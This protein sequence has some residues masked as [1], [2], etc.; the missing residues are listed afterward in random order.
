M[1]RL[2]D[3]DTRAA[4][5]VM[6]T[7]GAS[8]SVS[9]GQAYGE[10]AEAEKSFVLVWR[11]VKMRGRARVSEMARAVIRRNFSVSAPSAAAAPPSSPRAAPAER[12]LHKRR[13]SRRGSVYVRPL[14]AEDEPPR[15]E[16]C[17]AYYAV[18]TIADRVDS[19]QTTLSDSPLVICPN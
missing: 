17:S 6:W 12:N 7:C 15:H 3:S 13:A 4:R 1:Q 8:V 10:L 16:H 19:R 14:A 9:H 5:T 18:K 11:S 2:P